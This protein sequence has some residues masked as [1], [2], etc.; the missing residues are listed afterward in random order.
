MKK[1]PGFTLTAEIKTFLYPVVKNLSLTAMK[2]SGR[3]V[4]DED[5]LNQVPAPAPAESHLSD[6]AGLLSN[7]PAAHRE[8]LVMRIVDD[9][10]LQEIAEALEI[11]AGTVKSRLHNALAALRQDEKLKKY[12]G[13]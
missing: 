3:Y 11:P 12:F 9:M 8:V 10:T 2:K 4:S 7:L 6:L 13:R 1:F 5:A